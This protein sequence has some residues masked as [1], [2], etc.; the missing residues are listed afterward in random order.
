MWDW[1]VRIVHW[2]VVI[3]F[4]VLWWSAEN[5]QMDI[6]RYAGYSLLALLMWRIYWG[7]AGSTTARFSH[8][9]KNPATT[10]RY[11]IHA[12][13]PSSEKTFGH[14]PLGAYS[15][16]VLLVL[17]CAQVIL[18]L[19]A[20]DVDGWEAGPLN[21]FVTF[22]TGRWCATWHEY[23][24]NVL[25]AWVVLHLL[26]ISFY[27]FVHKHNLLL[28]MLDGKTSVAD[29]QTMQPANKKHYFIVL[30][31]VAVVLYFIV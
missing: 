13:Q 20:I 21:S 2:S 10:W 15:V 11:A 16:V 30:M 5:Q 14:N 3:L 29:T 31:L 17:L 26:A 12:V 9:V 23:L 22:E 4:G 24:F 18:G 19:F 6:H 25:L 27:Y 8:F 28:P 1:S 7:F